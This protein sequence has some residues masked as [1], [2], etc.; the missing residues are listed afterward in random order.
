M[1]DQP[2]VE[3][4]DVLSWSDVV[5]ETLRH[6]YLIVTHDWRVTLFAVSVIVAGLVMKRVGGKPKAT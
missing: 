6:L 1:F 3:L 4:P 5:R 2:S